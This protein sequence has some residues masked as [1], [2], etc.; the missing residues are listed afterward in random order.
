MTNKPKSVEVGSHVWL[1]ANTILTK[2]ARIGDGS[3]VAMG[4]I[5][6]KSFKEENILLT[7][8]TIKK[9]EISWRH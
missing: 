2:G 6:I 1:C 3:V 8:N 9:S 7:G 5:V 4:S